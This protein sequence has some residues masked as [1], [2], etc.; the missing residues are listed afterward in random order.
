M[1][2]HFRITNPNFL[3]LVKLPFG[4]VRQ[5]ALLLCFAVLSCLLLVNSTA[6][7][8]K[9]DD[10]NAAVI[11]LAGAN[12]STNGKRVA[13]V[14]GNSAYKNTSKL[15]NP[16]NDADDLSAALK[17]FGF[18]VISLKNGTRRQMNEKLA[19]F[20]Q[21]IDGASAALV[22]YAGHG[23]QI[24]GANYLMPVDASVDTEA[25]IIDE[26]ISL[27][28]VLEELEGGRNRVNIVM[29]DACRDNPITG[30]FR[31]AQRGLS[32]PNFTPKGTV[33]V[34]ATDPGNTAAD[35]DGR[36]GTFTA[37]LLKAFKGKDLSLDGVL[38]V[39]S[40]EVE[41]QSNRKQTP[42]VNGPKT[43]QKNF[44]FRVTVSPSPQ[45]LDSEYWTSVKDS[46]DVADFEA[47]L[48]EYPQGQFK[49]LAENRVKALKVALLP[50]PQPVAPTPAPVIA[51]A[52]PVQVVSSFQAGQTFKDCADCPEM[53]VIPAGSFMM[54]SADNEEGRSLDE[55]PQRKVSIKRFAMGKTEVTQGEWKVVMGSSPSYFFGDCGDFCPVTMVSWSDAQ[56][57]IKKLNLKSGK[58]YR[59]PSEAEWEYAARAGTNTPFYTGNTVN[60]DQANFDGNDTYN[61][62]AIGVYREHTIKVGSFKPNNFGLFDMLGN[63][64]E[65]TQD[66]WH[67]SYKG[68]PLDGAAWTI[69]A[70]RKQRV[71]RGGSLYSSPKDLRSAKRVKDEIEERSDLG[72]IGF[73]LARTL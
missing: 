51:V 17:G 61:G 42:Y 39:A 56:E 33:I 60:T 64:M 32:A 55:G 13:L 44:H 31:S 7:A 67:D 46:K 58:N 66:S 12:N 34:Y 1:I 23:A 40:E 8:Q 69:G 53:V 36:N 19:E 70:Y 62:S 6:L 14:I 4:W 57:Y 63:V 68:A 43:V 73:R 54:G 22:Y 3:T 41:K 65:W 71:L 59:L 11:E 18:E 30:K 38:T 37:G 72:G 24:R 9:K 35:G 48:A 26:S 16:V 10:R 27:N 20:S 28:R 25:A 2:N 45:M 15:T 21:K 29:L 52:A 5:L 50:A 47:Y 49:R